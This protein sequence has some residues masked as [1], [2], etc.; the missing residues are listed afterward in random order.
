MQGTYFTVIGMT[1]FA[2]DV[3]ISAA[4]WSCSALIFR[5]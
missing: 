3:A 1:I 4:F 2:F 5:R